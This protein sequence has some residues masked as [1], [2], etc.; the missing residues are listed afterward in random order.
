MTSKDV[1]ETGTTHGLTTRIEK[2]FRG[3][4][5]SP[6][7]QPGPQ[8]SGCYF[9]QR[10][11]PFSPTLS[12]DEDAGV[13]LECDISKSQADQFRDAQASGEAQMQHRTVADAFSARR[14]GGV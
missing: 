2:E 14:L 7:G 5:R 10:Q 6:N 8:C 4:L 13:W 9:P 12:V 11:A 1:L 3:K